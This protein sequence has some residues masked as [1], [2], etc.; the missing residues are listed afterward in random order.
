MLLTQASLVHR[1]PAGA[2]AVVCVDAD[3]EAIARESTARPRVDVG[4]DH[5]AYVIYTSGSTGRPKGVAMHH[6]PLVNLLA[7]QARDWRAPAGAVTLQF[8]TISFDASFHELFSAWMA[9]GA[10]VLIDEALRYD[11]AGLLEVMEREGVE[12]VFMP[13]VALQQLAEVADSRGLVPSRLREVQTAGE[14]VRVTE[15]MR[16]WLGA[17]GA[18]LYNHYGPSETHVVT[19]LAL[20]GDPSAWPVLPG[21]GIPIANT[22]CY[23]V[24]AGF[25][26]SP[27]G[28]P[29]ELYLGGEMVARGYL[30]RP[31]LTAERFLPDPFAASPGA[32]VY[33][34]GDRARWLADGTLAFLGRTDEQV[35]IRGFRIEPGEV[36]AV[37]VAHPQVR[38]AVAVVREDAPG[39][40]RLV[41]YVVA[42][43]GAVPDP[44]GLRAHL[45]G[46]LPEYMVPSAVVVLDAIPLTPSTSRM[47]ETTRVASSEWP[48]RSKKLSSTLARSTRS[49]SA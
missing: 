28:V 33:R 13:A 44:A 17:L 10:V 3:A 19:S 12:R 29:G 38:E 35:K 36:E 32:R 45:K 24:D 26:P 21:I 30:G 48:P 9:G 20:E 42:A 6:R 39:D 7:W 18:P 46:R 23:V 15:P 31:A 14:Q 34:T 43:E 25:R 27:V 2:A 47:R 40:R 5:L 49:T 22:Q 11:P 37:L 16:R 8:A 4:A 1:L 41:A